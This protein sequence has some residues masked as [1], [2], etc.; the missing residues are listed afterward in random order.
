MHDAVN[1]RD[2]LATAMPGASDEKSE[3]TATMTDTAATQSSIDRSCQSCRW[4][5]LLCDSRYA[6]SMICAASMSSVFCAAAGQLGRLQNLFGLALVKRSS[7]NSTG[8]AVISCKPLAEAPASCDLWLSRP[9]RC[10]GRPTTHSAMRSSFAIVE[11]I[12]RPGPRSARID[13]QRAGHC[14]VGIAHR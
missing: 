3:I 11:N 12:S 9:S 4:R 5:L 14:A 2:R 7:K 8:S 1:R 6:V 10:T 13:L